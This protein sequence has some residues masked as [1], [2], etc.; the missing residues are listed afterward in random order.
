MVRSAAKGIARMVLA[1]FQ[2]PPKAKPTP[3][4]L[5]LE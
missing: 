5:L 1:D 2:H 4:K 3:F